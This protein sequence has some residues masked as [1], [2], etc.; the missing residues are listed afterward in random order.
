MFT[1]LYILFQAAKWESKQCKKTSA[2]EHSQPNSEAK[3][4]S[5]VDLIV[6]HALKARTNKQGIFREAPLSIAVIY[7]FSWL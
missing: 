4:T 2:A 7:L 3:I 6:W 5:S 1:V